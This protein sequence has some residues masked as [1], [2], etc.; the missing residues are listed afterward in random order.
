M[1]LLPSWL[2]AGWYPQDF[3]RSCVRQCP[4]SL[5]MEGSAAALKSGD[6]VMAQFLWWFP[7]SWATPKH[8][9]H[10]SWLGIL[11]FPWWIGDPPWLKNPP[12]KK[13]SFC[14]DFFVDYTWLYHT[15]ILYQSS[16]WVSVRHWLGLNMV[17]WDHKLCWGS[18]R[19]A[20]WNIAHNCWLMTR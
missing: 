12:P 16:R 4:P 5:R 13:S 3:L 18:Q 2:A 19:G 7:K 9:S 8:P 20:D 10:G 14:W 11:A 1:R 6:Q 17:E 15:I